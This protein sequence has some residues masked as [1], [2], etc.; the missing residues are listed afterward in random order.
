MTTFTVEPTGRDDEWEWQVS[1]DGVLIGLHITQERAQAF[2][3]RGGEPEP[4]RVEEPADDQ[5]DMFWRAA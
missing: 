3:D 4:V 2:A 1:R 5:L